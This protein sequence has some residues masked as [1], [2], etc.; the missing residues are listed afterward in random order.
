MRWRSLSSRPRSSRGIN[1][2]ELPWSR[3]SRKRLSSS[4]G[5]D[6]CSDGNAS[7]PRLAVSWHPSQPIVSCGAGA[8]ASEATAADATHEISKSA[9]ATLEPDAL[10]RCDAARWATEVGMPGSCHFVAELSH[11]A[12]CAHCHKTET[13]VRLCKLVKLIHVDG[14]A[15]GNGY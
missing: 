5:E 13:I 7:F 1:S 15:D 11:D 14:I 6:V 10:H 3:N 8:Q 12:D 4:C 2:S 9:R